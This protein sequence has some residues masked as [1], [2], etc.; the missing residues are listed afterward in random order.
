MAGDAPASGIRSHLSEVLGFKRSASAEIGATRLAESRS[1]H[2]VRDLELSEGGTT[3]PDPPGVA[4]VPRSPSDVDQEAPVQFC[5]ASTALPL[6][7]SAMSG[8]P[9]PSALPQMATP[10]SVHPQAGLASP[11]S[12]NAN[13]PPS[14]H[15]SCQTKKLPSDSSLATVRTH[16]PS[17]VGRSNG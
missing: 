3:S 15:A 8:E 1:L 11:L 10:P 13:G 16:R 4:A 14:R 2:G 9:R 7:T 17:H 5:Q 6:P 12:H